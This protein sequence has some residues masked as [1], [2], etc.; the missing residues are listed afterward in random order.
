VV[1]TASPSRPVWR[2]EERRQFPTVE[3]CDEIPFESL[4]R[5]GQDALDVVRVLGVLDGRVAEEAVDGSEPGIACADTVL[6]VPFEMLQEAAAERRVDVREVESRGR[7]ASPL[8]SKPPFRQ[9][10]S[11]PDGARNAAETRNKNA[12]RGGWCCSCRCALPL[13]LGWLGW[14]D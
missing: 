13:W 6:A 11:D 7:L 3:E 10:D 4:G 2:R 1:P 14:L 8:V 5:D 9:A 12:S